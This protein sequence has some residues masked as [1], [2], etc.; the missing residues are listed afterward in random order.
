MP[1]LSKPI[2]RKKVRSKKSWY[3]ELDTAMSLLIR[4]KGQCEKCGSRINMLNHAHV[5]GRGNRALR[6]DIMNAMCLCVS[7]HFWWHE[8]PVESG[9]WFKEKYPERYGYLMREKNRFVDRTE[10]DY[11]VILAAIRNKQLDLLVY[12]D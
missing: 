12:K 1:R 10:D 4:E 7:C 8:Q 6:W 9:L 2:H 11:R 3:K 5:V